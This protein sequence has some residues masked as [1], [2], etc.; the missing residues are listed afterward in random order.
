MWRQPILRWFR[1]RNFHDVAARFQITKKWEK[2][3]ADFERVYMVLN[4][5]H[6]NGISKFDN[7]MDSIVS[8]EDD[9]SLLLWKQPP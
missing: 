5:F 3:W 7:F 9:E 4:K 2:L 8:S 1:E 6:D